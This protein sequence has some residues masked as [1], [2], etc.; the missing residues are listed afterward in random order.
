MGGFLKR[1]GQ[2]RVSYIRW[3]WRAS[4]VERTRPGPSVFE[5]LRGDFWV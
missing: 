3:E 5:G 1:R 4:W 2:A